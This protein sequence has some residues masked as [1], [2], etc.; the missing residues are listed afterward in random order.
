MGFSCDGAPDSHPR[1][2][3]FRGCET[4]TPL[5]KKPMVCTHVVHGYIVNQCFFVE[6]VACDQLLKCNQL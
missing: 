3:L 1:K 4:G 2:K 6:K 5:H